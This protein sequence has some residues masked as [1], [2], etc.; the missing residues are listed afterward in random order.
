M[1]ERYVYLNANLGGT[2]REITPDG[3]GQFNQQ[4]IEYVVKTF[5]DGRSFSKRGSCFLNAGQPYM[6][7]AASHKQSAA[8]SAADAWCLHAEI[9]EIEPK[10]FTDEPDALDKFL[11]FPFANEF[12]ISRGILPEATA[13]NPIPRLSISPT[14]LGTI[15]YGCLARW[16]NTEKPIYIVLPDADF[17]NTALRLMKTI[18]SAMPYSLRAHSGYITYPNQKTVPPTVSL[19]LLPESW[20][21]NVLKT[22]EETI[23][24]L[25]LQAELCQA[26][27]ETIRS[28][29]WLPIGLK[30]VVDYI[31]QNVGNE[32]VLT[33]L[34]EQFYSYVE[35]NGEIN[36]FSDLSPGTY[37][38][39]FTLLSNWGQM[40]PEKKDSY[41]YEYVKKPDSDPQINETAKRLFLDHLTKKSRFKWLLDRALATAQTF[42]ECC[43]AVR[44]ERLLVDFLPSLETSWNKVLNEFAGTCCSERSRVQT[45]WEEAI[46]DLKTLFSA[47]VIDRIS[48]EVKNAH[49]KFFN[50]DRYSAEKKLHRIKAEKTDLIPFLSACS[51]VVKDIEFDE[52]CSFA[53]EYIKTESFL[54]FQ[55]RLHNDGSTKIVDNTIVRFADYEN[56]KKAHRDAVQDYQGLYDPR[57]WAAYARSQDA[58]RTAQENI[59]QYFDYVAS[60]Q[61]IA[62]IPGM[63]S[64]HEYLK[65]FFIQSKKGEY[66]MSAHSKGGGTHQSSNGYS[67]NGANQPNSNFVP[68]GAGSYAGSSGAANYS[69]LS[70]PVPTPLSNYDLWLRAATDWNALKKQPIPVE[71]LLKDISS[72]KGEQSTLLLLYAEFERYSVFGD[73]ELKI[74]FNNGQTI[75]MQRAKQLLL[76][77]DRGKLKIDSRSSQSSE[78]AFINALKNAEV[79]NQR[80]LNNLRSK[81][82]ATGQA[83]PQSWLERFKNNM[84]AQLLLVIAIVVVIVVLAVVG[85][86]IGKNK[87]TN[88]PIPPDSTTSTSAQTESTAPP[89][90]AKAPDGPITIDLSVG[91]VHDLGRELISK[92]YTILF[93]PDGANKQA[94]Y[95][96]EHALQWERVEG[97]WTTVSA[98]EEKPWVITA[99]GA[100]RATF[101]ATDTATTETIATFIITV[102]DPNQ[103]TVEQEGTPNG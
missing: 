26:A 13:G 19:C 92:G 50:R 95:L 17:E 85:V 11:Q 32:S 47:E 82:E 2:D 66:R 97:H 96:N 42:S 52:N 45:E 5:R 55:A 102:N 27:M 98:D 73:S 29:T 14:L 64:I 83:Q 54:L 43:S 49:E 57:A 94:S 10:M 46:G 88:P 69:A 6:L 61:Q 30:S 8:T 56:L 12:D 89:T 23:P 65:A 60:G 41:V 22:A 21:N 67:I 4:Q 25:Y 38:A 36:R 76:D 39:A 44:P 31:E 72:P 59:T 18:Y 15:V 20:V 75:S 84:L 51:A 81:K 63:W 62:I 70:G 48:A 3:C 35:G 1:M 79:F 91:G 77:I 24:L 40:E 86:I 103:T 74:G 68:P 7:F 101:T 87:K 53:K 80:Q 78:I 58:Y 16:Y 33:G 99:N 37:G 93:R 9:R 34:F 71:A 100:G 28:R 90:T